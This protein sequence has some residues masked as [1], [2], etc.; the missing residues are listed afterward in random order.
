MREIA[1]KEEAPAARR[2][3]EQRS[4]AFDYQI[5]RPAELCTDKHASPN[6]SRTLAFVPPAA[7]APARPRVLPRVVSLRAMTATRGPVS[8]SRARR[9]DVYRGWFHVPPCWS[10]T[11]AA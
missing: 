7:R 10:V 1:E 6:I 3:A 5:D 11:H 2:G 9:T 8:R 4:T